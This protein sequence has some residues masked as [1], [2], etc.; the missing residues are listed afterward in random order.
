MLYA[1]VVFKK[2]VDDFKMGCRKRKYIVRD[3]HQ[4]DDMSADEY[5]KLQQKCDEDKSTLTKLLIQQFNVCFTAWAHVKAIRI[6]VESLLRYG[7]PPKFIAA[8]MIVDEKVEKEIRARIKTLHP[9]L[10]TPLSEEGAVEIGALQYEYPYVSLKVGN[11][12]KSNH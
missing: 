8:I 12:L 6:F 3:A 1:V 5:K 7:L 10:S 2:T 9:E 11:I 4:V